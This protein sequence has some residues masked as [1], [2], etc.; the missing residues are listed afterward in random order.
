MIITTHN[1]QETEELA[2]KIASEIKGGEVL[3]LNGTLGA[4]KTTF[5]KGFAKALGVTKT[6]VSPTFT[7]IKEYEGSSLTLYHI[8]MYR[9]EDE[10]EIYELGIEE[11]YRPD[12]VTVIEWNK[13]EELPD[14]V[15]TINVKVEGETTRNWEI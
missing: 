12:S 6:V 1:L 14:K 15:I 5:T 4:G 8:D 7:I 2:K 13:M 11:L 9:I 10:D 3:L